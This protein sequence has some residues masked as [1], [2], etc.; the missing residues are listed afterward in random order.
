MLILFSI[1]TNEIFYL[2]HLSEGG[3]TALSTSQIGGFADMPP[4]EQAVVEKALELEKNFEGAM[5]N[6]AWLAREINDKLFTRLLLSEKNAPIP[7]YIG[8]ILEIPPEKKKIFETY[9][10]KYGSTIERNN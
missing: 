3:Q 2:R 10:A 6:S 4:E 9:I 7:R 5:S 8:F 1:I